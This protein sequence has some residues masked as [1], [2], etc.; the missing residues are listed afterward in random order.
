MNEASAEQQLKEILAR[1][2]GEGGKGRF[3]PAQLDGQAEFSTLGV[4]SVD[5]M[6]FV[7]RIENEFRVD[8]LSDMLPDDLPSTLAG[9][10]KLLCAR[11]ARPSQ[12]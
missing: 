10:A 2:V 11:L 12:S 6:E 4:N 7:L 3:N 1:V 9:W 8:I 5:L